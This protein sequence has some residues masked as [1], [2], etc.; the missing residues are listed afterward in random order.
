M[1][2]LYETAMTPGAVVVRLLTGK[3]PL[4]LADSRNCT[5]QS[6]LLHLVEPV[7]DL[8]GRATADSRAQQ[9]MT[10]A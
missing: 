8:S 3:R 7:S 1:L 6:H 10:I 2:N 9:E 4:V 5:T